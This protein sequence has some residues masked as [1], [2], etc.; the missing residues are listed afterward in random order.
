MEIEYIESISSPSCIEYINVLSLCKFVEKTSFITT[1]DTVWAPSVPP[2]RYFTATLFECWISQT[3][4]SSRTSSIVQLTYGNC[5]G[6]KRNS[7]V[8]CNSI[9]E[10]LLVFPDGV[11]SFVFIKSA[12]FISIR[13]PRW[14]INPKWVLYVK[15]VLSN[16]LVVFNLFQAAYFFVSVCIGRRHFWIFVL[17]LIR[18]KLVVDVSGSEICH[19]YMSTS[20]NYNFVISIDME[21]MQNLCDSCFQQTQIV[22][23]IWM[24]DLNF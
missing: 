24:F 16:Y 14:I 7:V 9:G 4:G 11:S 1:A 6:Y 12:T 19:C 20:S 5:F 3:T 17:F 23:F 21:T 8:Y 10:S 18:Y 22:K 2:V 13:F 15:V